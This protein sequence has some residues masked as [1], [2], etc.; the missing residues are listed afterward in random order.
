MLRPK[1]I[2]WYKWNKHTIK[3]K[4]VDRVGLSFGEHAIVVIEPARIKGPQ[5]EA[6]RIVVR[7]TMEREGTLWVNSFPHLPITKKPA[8]TRIGKGKGSV[9]RFVSTVRSG[10]VIIEVSG[11]DEPTA[12]EAFRK[13]GTKLGIKSKVLSRRRPLS[14]NHNLNI[15]AN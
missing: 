15:V 13:A 2:S 11:V 5:F 1:R 12:L 3:R 4:S 9:D 10:Q 7:R 6:M 14:N 8:S